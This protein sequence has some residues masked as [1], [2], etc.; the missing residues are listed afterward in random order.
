MGRRAPLEDPP[1][2]FSTYCLNEHF[3]HD[4][5]E[6]YPDKSECPDYRRDENVT[7]VDLLWCPVAWADADINRLDIKK[8]LLEW[9]NDKIMNP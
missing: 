3:D 4:G 7:M 5:K 2:G 6:N 9:N 8:T 1:S